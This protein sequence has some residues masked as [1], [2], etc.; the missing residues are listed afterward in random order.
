MTYDLTRL[1]LKSLVTRLPRTNTYI[2][3]PD[4]LKFAVFYT[5]LDRRLLRPLLAADEPPA[6]PPPRAA[7]TTIDNVLAGY[8]STAGAQL[9]A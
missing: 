9:A 5:K 1:R 2:L 6:P 4:G 3:S 8:L 7:P